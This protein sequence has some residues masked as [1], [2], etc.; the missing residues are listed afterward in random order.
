MWNKQQGRKGYFGRIESGS[1]RP[2][3]LQNFTYI[4]S[5]WRRR[6]GPRPTSPAQILAPVLARPRTTGHSQLTMR[7]MARVGARH[8]RSSLASSIPPTNPVTPVSSTS[9]P[10]S[11]SPMLAP[12]HRSRNDVASPGRAIPPEGFTTHDGSTMD[13]DELDMIASVCASDYARLQTNREQMR[14]GDDRTE[15]MQR[16][17]GQHTRDRVETNTFRF[18]RCIFKTQQHKGRLWTAFSV[19]VARW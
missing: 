9:L 4:P 7:V 10:F 3:A 14:V 17:C 5:S 16:Q 11:T 2:V 18:I 12:P 6:C 13:A 15:H 1:N 19:D 8:T